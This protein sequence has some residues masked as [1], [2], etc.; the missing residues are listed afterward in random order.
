MIKKTILAISAILV[1]LL[2]INIDLV[3]YGLKQAKGQMHIIYNA[4]PVDELLA[5]DNVAD[6]VKIKLRLIQ[7]VRTYAVQELGLNDSD[8]YT[9]M[10]D[11][12]GKPVLWVVTGCKP[13]ALEAKEWDFP[14]V[15]TMPYKGFFI[16][17]DA[18]RT[19]EELEEEGYDAGVRT[20]GGWSTLGWFNDPILSNMLDRNTGELANLIIH[21]LVHATIFVKDSVDFNENLASFIAEKGAFM[22]LED[23]YGVESP[24]YA[25]YTKDVEDDIN[26]IAHILRG[27]DSLEVLYSSFDTD[28]REVVKKSKKDQMID[29]IMS[30]LDTLNLNKSDYLKK[31]KGYKPNNTYFMSFMRYR[32]KQNNLDN[33]YTERFNS[34]LNEFIVYL[35]NKHPYL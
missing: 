18:M 26:Y 12:Q 4:R 6:S 31:L 9:S 10:Y 15:G 27:A 8:N 14:V 5:D 21:E 35:S 23:T 24:V 3:I 33:L 13:Y 28:A 25:E 22:F 16:E 1:V 34:N 11:Q 29:R 20:V 2:L 32:S 30:S 19:M 7:Q 17:K